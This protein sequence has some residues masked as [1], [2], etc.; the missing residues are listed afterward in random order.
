MT[1]P[2]VSCMYLL[3]VTLYKYAHMWVKANL[4]WRSMFQ[5]WYKIVQ[6]WFILHIY[7]YTDLPVNAISD[8]PI[9]GVDIYMYIY[10]YI[11]IPYMYISC[12]CIIKGIYIW[13]TIYTGN[14]QSPGT[15]KISVHLGKKWKLRS[16]RNK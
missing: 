13:H 10:I 12:T 5:N 8:Y 9:L 6:F 15:F 16:K 14:L 3:Y 2:I 11:Y 4:K 1:L 7:I